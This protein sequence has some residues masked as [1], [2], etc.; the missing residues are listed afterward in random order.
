MATITFDTLKFAETLKAHGVPDEQAKGIAE[1]FRDAAGSGDF[2]TKRDIETV[3]QDVRE[4]EMRLD[5][6]IS[7]IKFDMVKWMAGMLLA[8]AGLVAALVKL[9]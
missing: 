9:L 5:A 1:A 3:R 8:Q 7:D 4:L 6:R 2:A